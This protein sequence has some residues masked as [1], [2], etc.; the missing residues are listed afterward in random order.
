VTKFSFSGLVLCTTV[1]SVSDF[2]NAFGNFTAHGSLKMNTN[3]TDDRSNIKKDECVQ[4]VGHYCQA[5]VS[6]IM[7]D[8]SKALVS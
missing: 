3:I 1:A 4:P 2:A 6:F 8:R 5:H 7:T